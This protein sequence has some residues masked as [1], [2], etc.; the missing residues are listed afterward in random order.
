M[1]LS[2][3]LFCINDLSFNL[4]IIRLSPNKI[5]NISHGGFYIR[6]YVHQHLIHSLPNETILTKDRLHEQLIQWK[7]LD[8][9]WNKNVY[10]SSSGGSGG[11]R[12]FF[13][14]DIE[15]NQRQRKILVKMMIDEGILS[16]SDICLNLFSSKNLYRSSEIFTDFCTFANC[17]SL[18]MNTDAH[19]EDILQVIEYFHPNV[20]MGSPF[21]LMQLAKGKKMKMNFEKIFFACEALNEKR[22]KYFREIFNCEKFIGFYGSAETGV[23]ACQSPN[24]SSTKIYLYPKE[25]VKIEIINSKIIVT[26]LIRTRNQLIRFDTG[27]RGRIIPNEEYSKY[28]L[29]EVFQSERLIYIDDDALSKGDI[30]QIMQQ[31]DLMEWQVIIDYLPETNG[32]EV[33]VLFRYVPMDLTLQTVLEETMR[34]ELTKISKM[35]NFRFQ[36]IEFNQLITDPISNKLLKIIDRRI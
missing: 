27:D 17:T 16:S 2:G 28:G 35:I 22:E 29:I 36:S 33:E 32:Q 30:E 6:P 1:N 7:I 4:G 15:Q 12:L 25:L 3:M 9:R 14:T 8:D 21:R 31:L 18:P 10:V 23:F 26:N 11:K 5:V 13:L 24:Y 34:N 20:L 19:D